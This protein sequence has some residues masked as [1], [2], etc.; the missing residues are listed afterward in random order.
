MPE[1]ETNLET[2]DL[3]LAIA[4]AHLRRFDGSTNYSACGM[5]HANV[6]RFFKTKADIIYIDVVVERSLTLH[7]HRRQLGL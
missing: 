6:Y 5:S 7:S 4:E 2:R 3:I 1:A